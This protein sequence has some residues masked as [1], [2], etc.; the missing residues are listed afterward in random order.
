MNVIQAELDIIAFHWNL[1]DIR[2]QRLA[3]AHHGKPDVLFFIPETLG[4]RGYGT[5]I[6]KDIVKLCMELYGT[7]RNICCREFTEL[8][9]LLKPDVQTPVDANSE[10]ELYIE[11]IQILRQY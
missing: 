10:L 11:L 5:K 7:A 9:R 4:A 6:N 2:S 1:H 3:Q 8:I